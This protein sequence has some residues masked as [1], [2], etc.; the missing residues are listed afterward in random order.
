MKNVIAFSFQYAPLCRF[1]QCPVARLDAYNWTLAILEGS[2]L[3][4]PSP[5]LW[6]HSPA[7]SSRPVPIYASDDGPLLHSHSPRRS[8]Q[9]RTVT[10]AATPWGNISS[11]GDQGGSR[12]RSGPA[13]APRRRL[14]S[15]DAEQAGRLGK[16]RTP[17][18]SMNWMGVDPR[19]ERSSY[20]SQ[21]SERVS[22]GQQKS[23][24]DTYMPDYYGIP[25]DGHDSWMYFNSKSQ[26][27]E[28]MES[29]P[30]RRLPGAVSKVPVNTPASTSTDESS[31]P[32]QGNPFRVNSTAGRVVQVPSAGFPAMVQQ[33]MM[34][35]L[36]Q[37]PTVARNIPLPPSQ[38]GSAAGLRTCPH[39]QEGELMCSDPFCGCDSSTNSGTCPP[40][41][42]FGRGHR[43]SRPFIGTVA[44]K[45]PSSLA[46]VGGARPAGSG[47]GSGS[48]HIRY[49]G[50][51]APLGGQ[52]LDSTN[53]APT[54]GQRKAPGS[55]GLSPKSAFMDD[56]L[57]QAL[58]RA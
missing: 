30:I 4:W 15:P 17:P 29:N 3:A 28:C 16:Y 33:S 54:Q 38:P 10:K 35:Q 24:S 27:D 52:P 1:K 41:D 19:N 20:C 9:Q 13:T 51:D 23:E 40:A 2:G 8:K 25:Q 12:A 56:V 50:A 53:V 34:G 18:P 39:I 37:S 36:T 26:S 6:L 48:N 14:A 58:S 45:G 57:M 32:G 5:S 31:A 7:P 44:D 55:K 42:G 49:P 22:V 47:S 21:G 46:H 11:N 43:Y